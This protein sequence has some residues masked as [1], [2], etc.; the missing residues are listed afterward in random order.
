MSGP[1]R[2]ED[3]VLALLPGFCAD[4]RAEDGC[5]EFDAYRK[6]GDESSYVLLE[7]Y[8]SA[9]AFEA[10]RETPHFLGV[11]QQQIAP[12]LAARSVERFGPG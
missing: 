9:E 1:S 4:S 8:V 7:R 10:H 11:M 5:I 12:R 6:V 3:A 2:T